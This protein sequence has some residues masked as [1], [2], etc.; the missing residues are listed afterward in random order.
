MLKGPK[1]IDSRG[2][3]SDASFPLLQPS[4]SVKL[5]LICEVKVSTSM[6]NQWFVCPI[7]SLGLDNSG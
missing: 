3:A 7:G 4:I 1:G 2:K 6:N 5:L